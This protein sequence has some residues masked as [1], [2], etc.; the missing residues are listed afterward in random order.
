MTLKEYLG[1]LEDAVRAANEGVERASA[2]KLKADR[3]LAALLAIY[4]PQP[5]T[6]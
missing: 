3:Q 5:D 2:A 4:Q 6:D 1:A